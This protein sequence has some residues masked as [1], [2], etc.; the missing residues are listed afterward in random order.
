M[1]SVIWPKDD[2]KAS[3]VAMLVKVRLISFGLVMGVAF[4]LMA[5]RS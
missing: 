4:L 3:S 5:R 1:L 2:K